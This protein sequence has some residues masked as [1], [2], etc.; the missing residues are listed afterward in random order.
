MRRRRIARIEPIA[1]KVSPNVTGNDDPLPVCGSLPEP[2]AWV[3]VVAVVGTVL[4][5]P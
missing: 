3:V 5:C 4:P 1:M 2:G